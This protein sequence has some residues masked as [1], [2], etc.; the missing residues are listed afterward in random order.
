MMIPAIDII[1]S[2]DIKVKVFLPLCSGVRSLNYI[3]GVKIMISREL[4]PISHP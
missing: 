3:K 2:H 4:L 1:S